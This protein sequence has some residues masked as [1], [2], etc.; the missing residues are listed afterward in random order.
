MYMCVCT[1]TYRHAHIYSTHI[2]MHAI[3]F[4][5]TLDF[6]ITTRHIYSWTSYLL[7]PSHFILSGVIS[8]HFPSSTLDTYR[9]GRDH[10][11]VS[12]LLAFSYHSRSKNTGVVWLSLLQ[13]TTFCQNSSTT[14]HPSWVTLHGM[15][16][17]FTE[18]HKPLRHDKA[19]IKGIYTDT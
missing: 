13:W 6:T 3:L 9:P 17:S 16:H 2:N 7:W 15:A 5:T 10:L 18:L 1:C 11:L 14:T 12:C 4:F 8:P 19:V